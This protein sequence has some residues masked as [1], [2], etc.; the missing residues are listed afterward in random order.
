MMLEPKNVLKDTMYKPS[1][2][3]SDADE[4]SNMN[5]PIFGR[6]NMEDYFYDCGIKNKENEE[7]EYSGIFY[8]FKTIEINMGL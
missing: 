2:P 3:L 1:E 4:D 5:S 7:N 8:R 6:R